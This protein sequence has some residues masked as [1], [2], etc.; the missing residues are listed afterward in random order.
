VQVGQLDRAWQIIAEA[1]SMSEQTAE[2]SW[3]AELHRIASE[4]PLA[5]GG[6]TSEAE[7]RFR[8]AI[9]TARLQAA[10]GLELRAARGLVRLLIGQG[11]KAEARDLLAP[12]L[13]LV[14]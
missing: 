10:K 8:R 6:D 11:K 2:H 13:R 5:K 14:Y 3:D 7:A 12:I 1:Q 4:I 9:D